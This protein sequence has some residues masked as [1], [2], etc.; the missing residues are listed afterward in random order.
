M[1]L[2]FKRVAW[3]TTD[4]GDADAQTVTKDKSS[5]GGPQR[6]GRRARG[7]PEMT[8]SRMPVLRREEKTKTVDRVFD[9]GE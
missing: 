6:Q 2:G 7:K 1:G 9:D 5:T 3:Q 8:A 4:S